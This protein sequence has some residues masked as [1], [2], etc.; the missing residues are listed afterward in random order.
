M[1]RLKG[2]EL[3]NP[4][5]SHDAIKPL[6]NET[7]ISTSPT[8]PSINAMAYIQACV[9]NG[10]P[11]FMLC[12]YLVLCHVPNCNLHV[13]ILNVPTY[14]TP[15]ALQASSD[16][17]PRAN[18]FA[19]QVS[20]PSCCA[21]YT[22]NLS[23]RSCSAV[24]FSGKWQENRGCAH[25]KY[26]I[27]GGAAFVAPMHN[28]PGE[29][30]IAK[31]RWW[32]ASSVMW[33]IFPASHEKICSKL[34][35]NIDACA[36]YRSQEIEWPQTQPVYPQMYTPPQNSGFRTFASKNVIKHQF[37]WQISWNHIQ[38][39]GAQDGLRRQIRGANSSTTGFV[40]LG[41]SRSHLCGTFF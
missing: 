28:K 16:T 6:T 33:S 39:S 23:P 1:L 31:W 26:A 7:R 38:W 29:Y 10:V 19:F 3:R 37:H 22:V 4:S 25:T 36:N 9:Y 11:H 30:T 41:L 15:V 24:S 13:G 35:I 21:L 34:Q 40:C 20:R 5:H 17:Y 18:L 14:F 32:V 2:F 27:W 8:R 12:V